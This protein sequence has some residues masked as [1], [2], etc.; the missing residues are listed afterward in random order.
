[1]RFSDHAHEQ[2]TKATTHTL[3]TVREILMR[4]HLE[5]ADL[6]QPL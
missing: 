6:I 5:K 4:D 1:V 3:A 2:D